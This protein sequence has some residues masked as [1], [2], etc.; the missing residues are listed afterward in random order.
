MLKFIALGLTSSILGFC[1]ARPVPACDG[2]GASCGMGA[3]SVATASAKAIRSYS[4]ERSAGMYR[5]Q[6]MRGGMMGGGSGGG[7]PRSAASKAAGR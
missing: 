7:V 2:G 6:M 4:Y 1:A 3:A 5:P